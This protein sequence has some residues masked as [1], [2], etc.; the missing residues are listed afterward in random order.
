MGR[1]AEAVVCELC[2]RVTPGRFAEKHHLVPRS[3]GGEETIDVCCHCGDHVHRL[4]SNKELAE[5]YNTLE[6]LRSEERMQKWIRWVSKR[7][8]FTFT[9][10]RKKGR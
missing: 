9:M 7:D 3:K 2:G 6:A 5:T 10:K 4:F 8:S 1:K